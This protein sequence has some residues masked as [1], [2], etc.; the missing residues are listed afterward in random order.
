MPT[1]SARAVPWPCCPTWPAVCARACVPQVRV[2]AK[3]LTTPASAA[4][5]ASAE[6]RRILGFFINSLSN[7]QVID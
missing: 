2:L 7:P 3:M 6:A 4:R 1:P 5:P